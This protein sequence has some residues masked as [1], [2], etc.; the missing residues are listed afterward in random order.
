MDLIIKGGDKE[1]RIT[2]AALSVT[3]KEGAAHGRQQAPRHM[4]NKEHTSHACL[5]REQTPAED[6]EELA[7]GPTRNLERD[8]EFQL[9]AHV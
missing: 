2:R 1:I 9:H 4:I 5:P 6:E 8:P 7:L 3:F